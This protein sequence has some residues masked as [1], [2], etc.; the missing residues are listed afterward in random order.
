MFIE[1]AKSIC[2]TFDNRCN[3]NAGDSLTFYSDAN[4]SNQIIS[5]TSGSSY[6]PLIINSNTVYMRFRSGG[7]EK[8]WGYHFEVSEL[9]PNCE[10]LYENDVLDEKK[11]NREWALWI[12]EVLLTAE[13]SS[14]Y[15]LN[16][17]NNDLITA[18]VLALQYSPSIE[19]L[20][21]LILTLS[22]PDIVKTLPEQVKTMLNTLLNLYSMTNYKGN[23]SIF[24][25]EY[26]IFRLSIF[27]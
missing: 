13:D 7:G 12:C 27:G 15:K 16:K 9:K 17:I 11:T 3:V 1:G 18:T 24:F 19:L 21:I 23:E 20:K 26:N 6:T 10:W 14:I 22:T 2:I 4:Y 5:Y 25:Y 8:S